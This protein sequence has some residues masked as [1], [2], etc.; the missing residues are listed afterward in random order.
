MG[1]A[2]AKSVKTTTPVEDEL[3]KKLAT[4]NA[5]TQFVGATMNM[6]WRLAITVVVPIVAGVKL[7]EHFQTAPSYT[8]TGLILAAAA[9]SAAVWAT[10]K[11]VNVETSNNLKDNR[12][13]KRAK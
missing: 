8:L 12:K 13:E 10:I 5:R 1:K 9:G 11:E 6:G 7:D 3:D 2:A 4:I